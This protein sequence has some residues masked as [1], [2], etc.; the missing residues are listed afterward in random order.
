MIESWLLTD[1]DAIRCA[2]DN[3]NGTANL[4]LPVHNRI[5]KLNNPKEV[6]FL[7]LKN[8]LWFTTTTT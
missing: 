4:N 1:E 7:A 6:L 2:A 8:S 3:R 5:E